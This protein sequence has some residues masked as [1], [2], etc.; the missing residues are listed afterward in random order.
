MALRWQL[1]P[2]QARLIWRLA[3]LMLV[4]VLVPVLVVL[5][6]VLLRW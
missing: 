5:L 4:L 1:R 3:A 2:R 6:V